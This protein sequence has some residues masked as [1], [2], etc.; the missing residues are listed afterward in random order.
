MNKHLPL[1]IVASMLMLCG[2]SG[3]KNKVNVVSPEEET[4]DTTAVAQDT[5]TAEVDS[6]R[7]VDDRKETAISEYNDS[8]EI[9]EW[10]DSTLIAHMKYFC[11]QIKRERGKVY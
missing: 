5:L 1:A 7:A 3:C 10:V 6:L 11:Q 8:I 2:F 9:A 4:E